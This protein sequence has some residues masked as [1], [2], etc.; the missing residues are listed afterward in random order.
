MT[1]TERLELSRTRLQLALS[2]AQP[3][4]RA[5]DSRHRLN[6]GPEVTLVRAVKASL[7]EWWA[8]SML[9]PVG[10]VAYGAASAVVHPLAQRHPFAVVLCAAAAGATLVWSRPWRWVFG[11]AVFAGFVPQLAWRLLSKVPAASWTTLATALIRPPLNR[12]RS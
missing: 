6:S 2:P 4:Q 5:S 9:R 10:Q 7:D 8:R 11:S 1:A 3:E 12:S